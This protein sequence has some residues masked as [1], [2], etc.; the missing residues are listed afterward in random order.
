MKILFFK[1]ATPLVSIFIKI[2][3]RSIWNLKEYLQY[4]QLKT[5]KDEM[6]LYHYE[7]KLRA[8]GS[9]VG[10]NAIFQGIP[11]FP[12]GAMGIFIAHHTIIGKN[13]IIFQQVTIGSNSL[14]SS[15]KT[16]TPVIGDNVYIGAGA[17]I[18]GHVKI[19]NNCRI[20]ANAVV[21]DDMPDNSVAVAASTRIIQKDSLD[22]RFFI[23]RGGDL[24]YYDDGVWKFE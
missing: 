12:H 22:N 17:K 11:Y 15:K 20:G 8:L 9:W 16:G 1:I 18:I 14:K 2:K 10:I 3:F 4:S 7:L 24:Y 21:V 5:I 19:G 13:V 6:L 23:E